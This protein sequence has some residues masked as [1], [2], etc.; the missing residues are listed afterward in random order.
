MLN[1]TKAQEFPMH[2]PSSRTGMR[3][4]WLAVLAASLLLTLPLQGTAWAAM[5]GKSK[6]TVAKAQWSAK[7]G[8][9]LVTGANKSAAQAVDLYDLNGRWLASATGAKFSL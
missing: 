6:I 1:L 5:P 7:T 2:R 8:H 9:L 3:P 4:S